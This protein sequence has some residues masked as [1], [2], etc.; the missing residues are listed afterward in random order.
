MGDGPIGG[1]PQIETPLPYPLARWIGA[2]TLVDVDH[3]VLF[4]TIN[5]ACEEFIQK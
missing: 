2:F 5:I 1:C 3:Y 4:F